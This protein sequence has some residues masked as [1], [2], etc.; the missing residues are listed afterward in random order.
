MFLSTYSLKNATVVLP[1]SNIAFL[2]AAPAPVTF[3]TPGKNDSRNDL[4][5]LKSILSLD[6][7]RFCNAS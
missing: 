1:A 6:A 2:A 5:V 7:T 3:F 4:R